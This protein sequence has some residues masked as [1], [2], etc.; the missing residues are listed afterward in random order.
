MDK[1]PENMMEDGKQGLTHR[2][3]VSMDQAG[4]H[5]LSSQGKPQSTA[6]LV[7]IDRVTIRNIWQNTSRI[8]K[9]KLK[10]LKVSSFVVLISCRLVFQLRDIFFW[11]FC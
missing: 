2:V 1:S 4:L 7:T 5:S 10:F 9:R 6:T 8:L 3:N 11:E